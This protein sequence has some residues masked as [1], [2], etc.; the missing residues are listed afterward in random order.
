MI[1][2]IPGYSYNPNTQFK[3]TNNDTHTFFRTKKFNNLLTYKGNY[4]IVYEFY[5]FLMKFIHV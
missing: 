3:Y 2:Q 4:I 1:P 5:P